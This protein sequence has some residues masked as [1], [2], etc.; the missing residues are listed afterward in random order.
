MGHEILLLR[1]LLLVRR[2]RSGRLGAVVGGRT[3]GLLWRRIEVCAIIFATP[4]LLKLL[5]RCHMEST[6]VSKRIAKSASG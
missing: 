4:H 3:W 2:Q 6:V 5:D 1:L